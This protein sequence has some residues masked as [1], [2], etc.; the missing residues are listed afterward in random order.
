MEAMTY[1]E[2][3][4]SHK[5]LEFFGG[6]LEPLYT[7]LLPFGVKLHI[8]MNAP[9]VPVGQKSIICGVWQI[10]AGYLSSGEISEVYF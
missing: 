5:K 4:V 10:P 8:N 2:L 3:Q 1:E 7:L 9:F 6:T